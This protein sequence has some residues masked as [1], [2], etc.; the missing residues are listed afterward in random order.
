MPRDLPD[1]PNVAAAREKA[2]QLA[3]ARRNRNR[4]RPTPSR[5]TSPSGDMPSTARE[6]FA[7]KIAA[8]M[9]RADDQVKRAISEGEA[10]AAHF[11]RTAK[12]CVVCRNAMAAPGGRDRHYSCDPGAVEGT[13]CSCP[14]DCSDRLHGDGPRDCDPEC[15][16][17]RIRRGQPVRSRSK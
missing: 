5:S 6:D 14:P 3:A 8:G 17:C 9:K 13:R 7:A 1:A 4:A 2:E 16:P 11:L 10:R 15:A 12:R